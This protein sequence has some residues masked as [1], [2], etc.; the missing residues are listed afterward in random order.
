MYQ[1]FKLKDVLWFHRQ[2]GR[3]MSACCAM[4]EQGDLKVLTKAFASLE[5]LDHRPRPRREA[6]SW[7]AYDAALCYTGTQM[8]G[9]ALARLV[10]SMFLWPCRI[11]I[12]RGSPSLLAYGPWS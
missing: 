8:H 4:M 3:N 10:E 1:V 7:A 11:A 9:L 2:H 5:G 6:F 12:R